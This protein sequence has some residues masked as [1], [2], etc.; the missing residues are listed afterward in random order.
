PSR[1]IRVG[2]LV[3]EVERGVRRHED[4]HRRVLDGH[5]RVRV[6]RRAGGERWHLPVG[7]LLLLILDDQRAAALQVVE[8]PPVVRHEIRVR[9]RRTDADDDGVEAREIAGREHVAVEHRHLDAHPAYRVGYLVAA[10]HDVAD[11]H[12]CDLQIEDL[13]GRGGGP[14]EAVRL[15]VRVRDD[16]YV[17]R[18]GGSLLDGFGADLEAA[19]GALRGRRDDERRG[20]PVAAGV[21]RKGSLRGRGRPTLRKPEPQGAR[22]GFGR[23]ARCAHN[24]L[25]LVGGDAE[26]HDEQRRVEPY[27]HA[28]YDID[29][30]AK[31]AA[32]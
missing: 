31:L 7:V 26:W 8:H 16:L 15:D 12:R 30:A 17:T 23:K 13:R 18:E 24:E 4:L 29:V 2:D 5:A 10:A 9:L 20:G 1:E 25:L 27:R 19:G 22:D 3:G 6:G 32:D 14:V 11:L 28:R 21:E